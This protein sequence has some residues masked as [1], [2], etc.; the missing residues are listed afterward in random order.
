MILELRSE[1]PLTPS[2]LSGP[3]HLSQ[4]PSHIGFQNPRKS[5]TFVC[6]S[7][8]RSAA[9]FI[10]ATSLRLLTARSL[11]TSFSSGFAFSLLRAAAIRRCGGS[12][13]PDSAED[14]ENSLR[15]LDRF[16]GLGGWKGWD[17]AEGDGEGGREAKTLFRRSRSGRCLENDVLLCACRSSA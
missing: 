10:N 2:R 16:R 8:L 7:A 4:P 17:E 6:A 3:H 12:E 11:C 5:L 15:R 13:L 9:A 14:E 1:H